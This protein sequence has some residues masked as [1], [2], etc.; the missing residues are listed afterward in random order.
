MMDPA[1]T[2]GILVL[3]PGVPV[4]PTALGFSERPV[5][6]SRFLYATELK[7]ICGCKGHYL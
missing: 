3:L 2:L 4:V 5:R 7:R 1:A 6:K